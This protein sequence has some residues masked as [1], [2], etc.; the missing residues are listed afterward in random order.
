MPTPYSSKKKEGENSSLDPR[1]RDDP[2]DI[3]FLFDR[4]M[5]T[6]IHGY[7][8]TVTASNNDRPELGSP[9]F[10]VRVTKYWSRPNFFTIACAS[11][12]FFKK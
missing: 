6:K 11:N 5:K 3:F 1:W 2:N 7:N 9:S 10:A 12:Q 8:A 4:F